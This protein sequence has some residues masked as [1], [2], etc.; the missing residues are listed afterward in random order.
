[1]KTLLLGSSGKIG[2]FFIKKNRN[3]IHTFF[4][5]RIK[6]GIKFDL[7]KNN[8]SS[9]IDKYNIKRVIILSAY[10][11]PD[12]CYNHKKRS[13]LLNVL[14]TKKI[15]K[16]LIKKNIFFIFFSSEF[17]YKGNK[18][19][20]SEN[21][22]P[23]PTTIYGKQ[24]LAIEQFIKKSTKNYVIFRIAKTYSDSLN[25]K[26]FFSNFFYSIKKKNY[27]YNA[28][29][30]QI[31][32]P[33]FV[34]DIVRI[35]NYFLKKEITGLFNV[36]GPV[37]YSRYQCLTILKNCLPTEIKEKINIRKIKLKNIKFTENRP[38]N[39]SMN[40]KKIKKVYKF[41]ITN[42][43]KIAKIIVKK[44]FNKKYFDQR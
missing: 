25:E 30:D 39:L 32:N 28:A 14:S 40:V 38:H 7:N 8:I 22:I 18:K 20:Y 29:V 35:T 34:K 5:K 24:K 37:S 6:G 21:S 13:Q 11:D 27:N 16:Q 10:S 12:F 19:N 17:V 31:F 26:D 2:K 4:K 1:M 44:K 36:G 33:L 15:I 43:E 41:K 42:F 9:V 3:L 23:K